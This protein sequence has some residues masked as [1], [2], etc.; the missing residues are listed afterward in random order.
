MSAA[1]DESNYLNI[2]EPV[3]RMM[4]FDTY[5]TGTVGI[6]FALIIIY[7]LINNK[8]ESKNQTT[9]ITEAVPIGKPIQYKDI[10]S[11]H[12]DELMGAL[13][14]CY[15]QCDIWYEKYPQFM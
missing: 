1:E 5:I 7:S 14:V 10:K 8:N 13:N 6:T 12:Y 4:I 9:A 15:N 11:K 2:K 3:E